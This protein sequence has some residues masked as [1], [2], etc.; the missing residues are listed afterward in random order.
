MIDAA[1]GDTEPLIFLAGQ[2]GT[3]G[4]AFGA[5]FDAGLDGDS[6]LLGAAPYRDL[7]RVGAN[8][9]CG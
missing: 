7:L 1:P 4:S 5:P 9:H 8:A 6:G 3:P 2:E